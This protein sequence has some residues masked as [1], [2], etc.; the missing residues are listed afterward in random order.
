MF[1]SRFAKPEH[2]DEEALE[3]NSFSIEQLSGCSQL[4]A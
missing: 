3:E 1:L 2:K 4:V